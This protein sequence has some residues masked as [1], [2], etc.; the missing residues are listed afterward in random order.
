MQHAK[1][2][3]FSLSDIYHKSNFK[4][5][6]GKLHFFH[7]NLHFS[8]KFFIKIIFFENGTN[9][10]L[11]YFRNQIKFEHSLQNYFNL[12]KIS[13]FN[14]FFSSV[15]WHKPKTVAFTDMHSLYLCGL[16]T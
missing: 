4:Y 10:S 14:R 16:K 5:F 12:C 7:E 2:R 3:L 15:I 13:T 1:I 6:N 8:S 11:N 9:F